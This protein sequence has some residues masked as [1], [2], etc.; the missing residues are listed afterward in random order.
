MKKIFLLLI[1]LLLLV[2]C[3][4]KKEKQKTYVIGL[5]AD[6]AP[7]EYR[8]GD[9]IVGFDV[10]LAKMIEEK[11]GLKLEIQDIAFAGLLPALQTGKIDAIISGMSVTEERKKAVNFSVPYF[12]VS[13]VII[14]QKGNT[15]IENKDDLVGKS[16]GV[17]IGTT[18]DTLAEEIEGIDLTKYNKTYEAI[19]ALNTAKIDAIILD[20]QQAVNF[21]G[22]NEGLMIL[23]T[24]LA[25]EEYAIAINK[26]N[27]ELLG[28][29]DKA[30]NEIVGSDEYNALIAKYITK[31]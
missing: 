10:D 2:G 18:S 11:S 17:A 8:D 31:K 30:L 21:V 29:V 23:Q 16:V 27:P 6:F 3:G 19:L 4:T 14:V 5:S 12:N 13:Q 22:Q 9:K 20:Y 15:A 26:D 28:E 1:G 7:F 24:E 25:K